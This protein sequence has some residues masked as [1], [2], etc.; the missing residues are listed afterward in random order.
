MTGRAGRRGLDSAGPCRGGVVSAGV[1]GRRGG[2]GHLGGSRSPVVV[3]AHLQP[4]GQPGAPL[5]RRS[6][7]LRTRPLVRAVSRQSPPPRPVAASRSGTGAARALRV[8][9]D[10]R[11]APHERG[12]VLARIYHESDLL[13]AEALA[14]GLFDGLDPPELAAVVSSCTFETRPGASPRSLARVPKGV[15]PRLQTLAGLAESLQA[16]EQS[17]HLPRTRAPDEG[18]AD[19]AWRWA[20]GQ[21][22]E[23]VLERAELAPG[24]FVRNI[25]QLID[26]LRQLAVVAAPDT[27]ATARHAAESLH[28]GVVAASAGPALAVDGDGGPRTPPEGVAAASSPAVSWAS[29]PGRDGSR[30]R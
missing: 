12:A 14:E 6:G 17:S 9:G 2:A 15:A 29:E 4:G 27:A 23:H 5:P 1:D 20:R 16:Q 7:P 24:D 30:G 25:K 22:L 26:L 19:V 3:P 13:V 18:F 28:R 10:R 8:R 11:L 21:R